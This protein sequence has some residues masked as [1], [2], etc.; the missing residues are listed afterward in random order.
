MK[1]DRL[2]WIL[3]GEWILGFP[4]TLQHCRQLVVSFG[5]EVVKGF[6]FTSSMPKPHRPA[7]HLEGAILSTQAS[8]TRHVPFKIDWP[9]VFETQMIYR[10]KCALRLPLDVFH[11]R[12]WQASLSWSTTLLY[13]SIGLATFWKGSIAAG[14]SASCRWANPNR[15][16]W[17]IPLQALPAPNSAQASGSN[18]AKRQDLR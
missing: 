18:L 5:V 4:L 15:C 17:W 9:C 6:G 13:C 14:S 3:G 7:I 8:F 11:F 12:I 10:P 16:L 1:S 2:N